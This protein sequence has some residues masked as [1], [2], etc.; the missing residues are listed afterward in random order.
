[1]LLPEAEMRVL[2][3]IAMTLSVSGTAW[4][5]EQMPTD[6][7]ELHAR[8]MEAEL[9]GDSALALELLEKAQASSPD[10]Q[11][12][13]FDLRRL[14][15]EPQPAV[16]TTSAPAPSSNAKPFFSARVLGGAQY[17][18]NVLVVPDQP[19]PD[20]AQPE[21]AARALLDG[22]FTFRLL[23]GD[24]NSSLR[25]GFSAGPHLTD[26]ATLTEFDA[27]AARAALS[28]GGK[29][30]SIRWRVAV[31]NDSLFVDR[32][33]FNRFLISGSAIGEL[34]YVTGRARLGLRLSGALRDFGAGN[35]EGQRNDRDGTQTV[36]VVTGAYGTSRVAVFG[37]A[38]YQG[39]HTDGVEQTE[40]GA[41]AALGVRYGTGDLTLTGS[42][43]YTL[44]DFVARA[45]NRVD[46]RITAG[47]GARY[48]VDSTWAV[49]LRGTWTENLSSS[50]PTDEFLAAEAA[51]LAGAEAP[52]AEDYEFSYTRQLATLGVEATW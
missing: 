25:A 29:S 21:A 22:D 43:N 36:A 9:D 49:L 51:E 45:L 15:G 28:V 42:F 27:F 10:D 34:A 37:S 40:N 44:R 46:Q 31:R 20:A 11:L 12:I 5:Q 23:Q 8:A 17:D 7:Y 47:V 38:G 52:T 39:E 32:T 33:A 26:D 4:A 41:I 48:A 35:P 1:M 2:P 24:L 30:K 16:S 3:L 14:R 50:E 19:N 13:R 18:S 6:A